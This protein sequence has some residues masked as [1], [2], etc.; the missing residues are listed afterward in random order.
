[1]TCH[2][3][4]PDFRRCPHRRIDVGDAVFRMN[5]GE[6]RDEGVI[7]MLDRAGGFIIV[8]PAELYDA[9]GRWTGGQHEAFVRYT[10]RRSSKEAAERFPDVLEELAKR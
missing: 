5:V 7:I 4:P 10:V 8:E 1:M 6:R 9:E 3:C 2:F